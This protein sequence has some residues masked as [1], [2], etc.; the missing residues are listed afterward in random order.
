MWRIQCKGDL[1]CRPPWDELQRTE[2]VQ[3]DGP[4]VVHQKGSGHEGVGD[5]KSDGSGRDLGLDSTILILRGT[6]P[7]LTHFSP[8]LYNRAFV[9]SV[10]C[11]KRVRR[12]CRTLL[13]SFA[14]VLV[15]YSLP[16]IMLRHNVVV[17][18]TMVSEFRTSIVCPYCKAHF[19]RVV[20]T[21]RTML[22]QNPACEGA[23]WRDKRLSRHPEQ[24]DMLLNLSHRDKSA[25]ENIHWCTFD[26]TPDQI[27]LSPFH[28]G[29]QRGALPRYH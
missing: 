19:R 25:S 9:L 27:G 2:Q 28:Y 21:H 26:A 3:S 23:P 5:G 10:V 24:R 6:L 1:S 18:V 14:S 11:T 22:C 29:T 4:P 15:C 12:L 7:P 13:S 16:G 20:H 8:R 17:S